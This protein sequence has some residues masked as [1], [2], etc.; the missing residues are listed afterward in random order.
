MFFVD[1]RTDILHLLESAPVDIGSI[2][3][4]YKL[5]P[6]KSDEQSKVESC[7]ERYADALRISAF[8]LT[9]SAD[10][11]AISDDYT[12]A[13]VRHDARAILLPLFLLTDPSL[14]G[15]LTQEVAE[16]FRVPIP[17]LEMRLRDAD[18]INSTE[19]PWC[20]RADS[21][22]DRDCSSDRQ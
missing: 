4:F 19:R 11:D 8:R 6:W 9:G 17:V 7:G 5:E 22:V 12:A 13:L 1:P 3:K 14:R 16:H 20:S 10:V 15:R 21:D 2:A 18:V